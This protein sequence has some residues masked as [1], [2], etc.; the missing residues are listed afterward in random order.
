MQLDKDKTQ[1]EQSPA[2]PRVVGNWAT[3][4]LSKREYFAGQIL[5]A[6]LSSKDFNY[7]D[8]TYRLEMAKAAVRCADHLLSE[9]Q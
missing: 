3:P 1:G 8:D 7:T 6:F 4:G 5:A 2:F 9:L